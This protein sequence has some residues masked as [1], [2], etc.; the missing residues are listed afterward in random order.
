MEQR[1]MPDTNKRTPG[2]RHAC[3][4]CG[5][6]LTLELADLGASPVANDYID[7]A[8]WGGM[9]PFYPLKVCVC[10]KCRLAQTI[11]LLD[12]DAI[13]RA[14]YAYFSSH[15]TTWLEH[16]RAYVSAIVARFDLGGGS[17]V[18]EVASNDGY[19]LR[20]VRDAGIPC[21][22][23]E[24]CES[25]ALAARNI[26]IET[27]IEFFGADLAGRLAAEGMHADLIVANNVLA[28][29]PNIND[30]VRGVAT[31]LKPEGVATFEVQHLLRLMQRNQFD[32]IYHEHFSYL[33]L[34]AAS[35]V[36]A[37]AGLRVFD[38]E[39][40]PTHGGSI[41]FFVCRTD[42]SHAE[43]PNVARILADEAAYGLDGDA[44]YERWAENV[45]ATKRA[46]LGLL[47][48][49]KN[50]GKS[51]A[52]YGAPAKGVTLLNY[53]GIG[54]DFID[55]TVDRA[56]SKQDRLLPGVHVPILAP[57]AIL[58]RE[59]DYLLILPWNLKDEIE[60]QMASIRNWGGKFIVPIPE[61]VIE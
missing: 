35:K 40:L 29:V 12:H 11:D 60:S 28:H 45:R 56:P 38:V 1:L 49:L 61:P 7:P 43:S 15:S 4:H 23:V 3:R 32:T 17:R 18:V 6:E 34:M 26:G 2:G 24:P 46:L 44:A 25:V 30:F 57:E 59:P 10:S 13:F 19:L 39:E 54:K 9:E 53:C 21:L 36:F 20:Y 55:F 37:A 27:R 8:T 58:E 16:A 33:S 42:A 5:A 52:A 48:E 41:R 14:D 22:G 50:Q 47:I 51:I 31:L